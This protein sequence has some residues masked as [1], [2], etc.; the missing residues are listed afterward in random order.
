MEFKQVI[1]QLLWGVIG[2]TIVLS[3][4]SWVTF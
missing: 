3:L 1:K 4:L 2:A